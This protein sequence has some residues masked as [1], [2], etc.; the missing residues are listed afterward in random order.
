M[1]ERGYNTLGTSI[2]Y[3]PMSPP[4]LAFSKHVYNCSLINN[5]MCAI[6]QGGRGHWAVNYTSPQSFLFIRLTTLKTFTT[7]GLVGSLSE[8]LNVSITN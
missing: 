5:T 7:F 2:I 6:F 4:S 3:S 1:R 8:C